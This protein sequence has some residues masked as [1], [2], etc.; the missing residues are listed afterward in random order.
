MDDREILDRNSEKSASPKNFYI[1][2]VPCEYS[3]QLHRY[4]LHVDFRFFFM[5]ILPLLSDTEF[6]LITSSLFDDLCDDFSFS[7]RMLEKLEG[8]EDSHWSVNSPNIYDALSA[9]YAPQNADTPGLSPH[10]LSMMPS[11]VPSSPQAP[12]S[13]PSALSPSPMQD[14]LH[15]HSV[16][17]IP[18]T[19]CTDQNKEKQKVNT[20]SQYVL[21]FVIILHTTFRQ[22]YHILKMRFREVQSSLGQFLF[23]QTLLPFLVVLCVAVGCRDIRYPKVELTS[24]NTGGIG[25]VCVALGPQY[26]STHP[27]TPISS[28]DGNAEGGTVPTKKAYADLGPGIPNS[29]IDQTMGNY[30]DVLS[31]VEASS[32]LG[33]WK[34]MLKLWKDIT[35]WFHS[36]PPRR[37]NDSILK[38]AHNNTDSEYDSDMDGDETSDALKGNTSTTRKRKQHGLKRTSRHESG[39][40][41]FGDAE[42]REQFFGYDSL[43]ALLGEQLM[44]SSLILSYSI[45]SYS[46]AI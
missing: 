11:C 6:L 20:I 36:L 46:I 37:S 24:K 33:I 17:S 5:H 7:S 18:P 34:L 38:G 12:T 44:S 9:M 10:H 1:W 28:P 26:S 23:T 22:F 25:E 3:A 13:A 29:R 31:D 42:A 35:H 21:A 43:L 40:L 8:S 2:K 32:G 45:S 39:N 41:T 30:H 4:A 16:P 27:H 15:L 19:P 14:L